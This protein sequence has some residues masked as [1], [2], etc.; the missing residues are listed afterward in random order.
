LNTKTRQTNSL[1]MAHYVD[2]VCLRFERAGYRRHDAGDAA[3]GRV[4]QGIIDSGHAAIGCS[5]S[6]RRG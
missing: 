1:A 4:E 3:V 6:G 5:P 2:E